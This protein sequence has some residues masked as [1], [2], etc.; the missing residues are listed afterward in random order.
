MSTL[1]IANSKGGTGKTSISLN[2]IHHIKPDLIIDA[3]I[4]KG[5]SNLLSL[6]D[7]SIEV[8]HATNKQQIIEWVKTDKT[9]L[10]DC[11]GFDSDITRYAIS[12]ADFIVTPTSD[13]PTDQ[14]GLVE[15][16]K[17]MKAVSKMVDEKLNAHILLN[18]VHHS[19][20]DFSDFNDLL[21]GLEHL[22]LMPFT[23]PQSAQ[24]PKAAFK[25]SG[26]KSGAVAAKFD[27]ASKY[28]LRNLK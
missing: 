9:V 28:I 27:K 17:V 8:R 6:G 18:R 20:G 23:I 13:D 19:R 2:L 21:S 14:F 5:I 25:G 10:I 12:Q 7:N 24:I 3:D 15:F 11:G 22:E 16:N 4:H 1:C 26:V